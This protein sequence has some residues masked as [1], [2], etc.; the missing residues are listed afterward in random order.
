[1]RKSK[2]FGERAGSDTGGGHYAYELVSWNLSLV[3][4]ASRL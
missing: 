4:A 3:V 1:M 2:S